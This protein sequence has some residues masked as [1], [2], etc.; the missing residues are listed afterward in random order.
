MGNFADARAAFH[1]SKGAYD[2]APSFFYVIPQDRDAQRVVVTLTPLSGHG[3]P[4]RVA[5]GQVEE[6]AQWK[7]FPISVKIP[8]AGTWRFT[9]TVGDQHGC[10]EA[11]FR[12]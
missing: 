6:A 1:Q 9:V 8:S 3:M 12:D 7:Y 5:S 4:I 2:A 10:F 11:T